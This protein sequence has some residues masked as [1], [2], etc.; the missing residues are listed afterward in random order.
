MTLPEHKAIQRS[1]KSPEGA[2]AGVTRDGMLG[3]RLQVA[4]P[5]GGFRAGDDAVF[6]AAAVPAKAGD[7]ALDVGCG[8]GAALL[9]LASRV[10]GVALTGIEL[11]ADLAALAARN[12][13]DNGF[14][15]RVRVV[16]GDLTTPPVELTAGAFDHVF[17][18]PPFFAAN[19]YDPS[20]TAGRA[21]ARGETA[22]G[23]LGRWIDF[24]AAMARQG[25]SLTL[26]HR[27]ERL[28]EIVGALTRHAGGITIFPL[29]PG[30][31]KPAKRVIVQARKGSAEPLRRLAGL[32]L[33]GPGGGY[34]PAAEAVLRGGAALVL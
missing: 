16:T 33:H 25:G 11:Q 8:V 4:Q 17:A 18:N 32:E 24:M 20:P 30:A 19:A 27:G 3:G 5:A 14:G 21:L 1:V 22:A 13:G 29:L 28:T 34:T 15:Q 6:L 26:V 7:T 31:G 2:P 9:C 12:A 23:D 10:P